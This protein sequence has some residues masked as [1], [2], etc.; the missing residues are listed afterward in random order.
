MKTKRKEML[1]RISELERNFERALGTIDFLLSNSERKT[2]VS[3][4]FEPFYR[5]IKVKYWYNSQIREA[6]YKTYMSFAKVIKD[7]PE[8]AIISAEEGTIEKLLILDKAD[9]R[10]CN[11][12]MLSIGKENE[13]CQDSTK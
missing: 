4:S 6:S 2:V 9:G 11:G 8:Y 5:S 1:K 13:E 3:V 7:E 12:D 10:I